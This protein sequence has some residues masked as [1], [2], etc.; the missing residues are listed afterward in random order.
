MKYYKL[1]Y[2]GPTVKNT[3]KIV[4]QINKRKNLYFSDIYVLAFG[5]NSDQLEIYSV[6][7]LMQPYYERNP[8]FIVGICKGYDEAVEL[9]VKIVQ[10]SINTRGDCNLKEYL[11]IDSQS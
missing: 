1:L 10:E 6:K 4:K 8:L 7:Y 3:K 11:K 5:S 2:T 9:V